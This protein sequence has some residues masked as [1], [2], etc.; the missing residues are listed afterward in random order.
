LDV[1]RRVHVVRRVVRRLGASARKT[2]AEVRVGKGKVGQK[3]EKDKT[4]CPFDELQRL[5]M[6]TAASAGGGHCMARDNTSAGARVVGR[7]ETRCELAR[8]RRTEDAV[9]TAVQ[10]C[11]RGKRKNKN[12]A[13]AKVTWSESVAIYTATSAGGG[14]CMARDNTSAGARVVGR[15]ETRCELAR[16]RRT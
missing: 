8:A 1:R 9:V 14:H 7:G 12:T 2:K 11:R 10:W 5:V 4:N 6:R 13:E 3:R 16:A 15:G